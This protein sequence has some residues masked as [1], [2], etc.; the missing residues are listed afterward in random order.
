[1]NSSPLKW[2][3][4]YHVLTCMAFFLVHNIE[5]DIEKCFFSYNESDLCS[6][7]E[8]TTG[9]EWHEGVNNGRIF[10]FFFFCWTIPSTV[11]SYGRRKR[12]M[13]KHLSWKS[14]TLPTFLV[15]GVSTGGL[16]V[17]QQQEAVWEGFASRAVHFGGVTFREEHNGAVVK[18]LKESRA[19]K[20]WEVQTWLMI[21]LSQFPVS[22]IS[23]W[24]H[25]MFTFQNVH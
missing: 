24:I 25:T 11:S 4:Y 14:N 22:F 1:M 10:F 8:S 20:R 7:E 13:T 12:D 17:W 3:F 19:C 21:F 5:E 18:N 2:K 9:L 16:E 15:W 6:A 23:Y